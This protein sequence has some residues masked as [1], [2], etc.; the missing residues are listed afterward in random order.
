MDV[1]H[2]RLFVVD[3]RAPGERGVFINPQIVET[4]QDNVPYDEGCLSVPTFFAQVMRPSEVT[5][6]AYD[7][8]GKPF[9]LHAEG[10]YARAIQHEAD[11]LDGKLFIDH[12]EEKDRKRLLKDYERAFGNSGRSGKKRNVSKR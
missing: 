4:A 1:V 3:T 2:I 6:Q 11:H 10:L 9:T 5:V 7:V 8:N 12:M